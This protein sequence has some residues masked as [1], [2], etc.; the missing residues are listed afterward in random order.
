[1]KKSVTQKSVIK[2][3]QGIYPNMMTFDEIAENMDISGV[4]LV[5][6]Q[7]AL[8]R[9]CQIGRLVKINCPDQ[10]GRYKFSR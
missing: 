4:S 1:M 6:L 7:N 2:Y 9:L 8:Y 10:C 3:L 5:D